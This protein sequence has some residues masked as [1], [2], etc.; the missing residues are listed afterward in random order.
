MT[1]WCKSWEIFFWWREVH[2]CSHQGEVFR[3]YH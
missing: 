1:W 3:A 2:I